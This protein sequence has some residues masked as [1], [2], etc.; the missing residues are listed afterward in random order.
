MGD[1][2]L[3]ALF[4]RLYRGDHEPGWTWADHSDIH[5]LRNATKVWA[6]HIDADG[7]AGAWTVLAPFAG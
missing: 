6:R 1:E 4:E 2:D 5:L 7:Q 3:S